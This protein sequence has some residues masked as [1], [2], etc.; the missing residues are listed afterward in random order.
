[1]FFEKTHFIKGDIVETY[2]EIEVFVDRPLIKE[3]LVT[4]DLE[5]ERVVPMYIHQQVIVPTEINV[6]YVNE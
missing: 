5:I 4:K 1:M 2:K 3:L 6:P